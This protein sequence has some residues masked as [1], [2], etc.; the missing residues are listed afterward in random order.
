MKK[1]L[2]NIWGNWEI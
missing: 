1:I 2:A